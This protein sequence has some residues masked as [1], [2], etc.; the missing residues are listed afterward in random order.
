L[1][2]DT[3]N[4]VFPEEAIELL[5]RDPVYGTH[6]EGHTVKGRTHVDFTLADSFRSPGAKIAE[7]EEKG[8]EG[9]VVSAAPPLLYYDTP[10]EALAAMCSAVNQGLKRFCGDSPD[11]FR[12]MA[13]VPMSTPSSAAAMLEQA[14]GEGAVGVEVGTSIAGRRLD[15]PEFE[16]F[17]AAADRLGLPVL[18]HPAY[19][20]A[21]KPLED[22]Y[23][24]NVIGNMLETT[25]AIERLIC[26]GMLDRHP[27]VRIELVHSGG[28]FPYQAGRL[29]HAR[30]VRPELGDAP[31]DPWAYIGR[32]CVDTITHDRLALEYLVRRVGE[33]NVVMGTDLPFDMA[34]PNPMDEL[35]AAVDAA[36][37]TKIAESNPARLFGF[38]D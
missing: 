18:I 33:E 34:T 15:E 11:R 31:A 26:S 22:Y 25:I 9:A 27:T 20:E 36:T 28:Y 29:K 5:N 4:H 13:H 14:A 19:N 21:S 10:P 3:H 6:V 7:L 32:I 37:A 30:T 38:K 35:L 17:W 1:K 2:I 16:V 24:Q 12:W 8:L 23:L